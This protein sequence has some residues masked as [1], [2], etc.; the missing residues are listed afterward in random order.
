M[1]GLV[2]RLENLGV[3]CHWKSHF[4][5]GV[6]YADDLAL[7]APSPAAFRVMLKF[8]EEFAASHGLQ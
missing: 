4:V 1:D 6:C 2:V 3:G 7:L 8:C 5:G